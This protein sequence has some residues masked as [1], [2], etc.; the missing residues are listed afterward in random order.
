MSQRDHEFL[1]LL[2]PDD[3]LVDVRTL[4]SPHEEERNWT[5]QRG[6]DHR[7][8]K[9]GT[10]GEKSPTRSVNLYPISD[11]IWRRDADEEPRISCIVEGAIVSTGCRKVMNGKLRRRWAG[12]A[13][14][15]WELKRPPFSLVLSVSAMAGGGKQMNTRKWTGWAFWAEFGPWLQA[16]FVYGCHFQSSTR[17]IPSPSALLWSADFVYVNPL[18]KLRTTTPAPISSWLM[19]FDR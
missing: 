5:E 4:Q 10:R 11:R 3:L 17:P 6:E 19:P 18:S 12:R 1:R 15:P 7:G 14:V 16:R 2:L 9:P 8:L 13:R